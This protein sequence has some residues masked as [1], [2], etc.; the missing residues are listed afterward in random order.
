MNE[1]NWSNETASSQQEKSAIPQWSEAVVR[2]GA[3]KTWTSI[4][5][6]AEKSSSL[7]TDR[8][9]AISRAT[10][11]F[12]ACDSPQNGPI[13]AFLKCREAI[14]DVMKLGAILEIGSRLRYPKFALSTNAE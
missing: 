6:D 5:K 7:P 8:Q 11:M 14:T 4:R 3:A 2:I 10:A 12:L 9:L 1:N 13:V